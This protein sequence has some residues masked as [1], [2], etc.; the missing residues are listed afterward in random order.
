MHGGDALRFLKGIP[1]ALLVLLAA[2][3]LAAQRLDGIAAVV[4]DEV[5][6]ES[7][8]EEQLV[9]FLAQAK[10]R[11][12][13]SAVDTLRRQI[14]DQLIDDKLVVAEARHQGIT[15]SDA[16]IK[17]QLDAAIASKKQELGGEEQYAEQLKKE[18]LTEAKLRE[19][20]RGE[21]E[22]KILGSRLIDRLFPRKPVPQAEAVAFFK[23]H[24]DKFPKVPAQVRV[25]VIQIP[26]MPDSIADLKGRNAALAARKRILAGEKFAKVAADVSEDPTSA[27]SGGDLG[28]FMQGTMEP[29]IEAVAFQMK[30]GTLSDPVRTPYGW[31]IVETLERDTVKVG[32]RDSLGVNGKPVLEAHARH[33]LV[34]VAITDADIDR[35]Q[36]LAGRVRAEAIKGTNFGVLARRYSKYQGPHDEDGDL[37][38]I[39]MGALQPTIRDGLDSLEVGQISELLTNQLGFNIF[40][41]VDRK[42]ERPYTLD[43]VKDEL[44]GAVADI[45]SRDKYEAWVKG[46]RAKAQIEYR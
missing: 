9:N 35:A 38:F 33:I 26:P 5:V 37:G 2:G 4:N 23:A 36:K 27:H 31:H 15:V 17:K 46:L 29:A 41:L 32:G 45:Q 8:V 18:N 25:A 14:L 12:D 28:F 43:E 30:L 3:P 22:R 39:S 7:D 42:P 20:Y 13:S 24:P 6:L 11:P 40:K 21:L 34:R 10:L 16:E 44:P 19:K 1:I